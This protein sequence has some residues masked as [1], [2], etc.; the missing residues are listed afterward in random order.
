[1]PT[2]G[3]ALT[4]AERVAATLVA[5]IEARTG[6]LRARGGASRIRI[7]GCPNGCARPYTGDIGI[8]GRIPGYYALYVGGDFEGTR[9]SR[10]LLDKVALADIAD[11]LDPLFADFARHRNIGEGFGDF[12]HR[13]GAEHLQRLVQDNVRPLPHAG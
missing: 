10:R 8:V 12:C 3:L 13:V 9:L 6:T 11:T 1:M 2:C 7:T 4:E 5:E